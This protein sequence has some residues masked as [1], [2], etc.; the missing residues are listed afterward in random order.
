MEGGNGRSFG[1]DQHL[2]LAGM[3]ASPDLTRVSLIFGTR[4]EAIKLAPLVRAMRRRPG[5]EPHVCVTGQHREMLD[6]VLSAL[7]V[8]PDCDL[9][10]MRPRQGLAELTARTLTACDGYLA[11][12]C[13]SLVV[14]QG[15]TTTALAAAMAA[16]YRRI[17]VAHLEAGLRT[18]RKDS[19]F[20]EEINRQ[21]V[22]R[23]ADYHFAP[24]EGARQNLLAE[25]VPAERIH[26][27]GNTG[28]DALRLAL[29]RVRN[30]GSHLPPELAA[31]PD[32]RWVLVTAHRR[33]NWGRPV[34]AICR[35]VATLAEW[36]PEV[37]FVWPVHLNPSVR[38]PVRRLLGEAANVLL[39]DPLGYLAFVATMDRAWLILTDSGGIQEEA[40][41]LG[42]PVLVLRDTTERGEVG[43]CGTARLVGTEEAAIVAEVARLLTDPEAYAAMARVARP[44]G[45]G[46]ASNR[47]LDLLVPDFAGRAPRAARSHAA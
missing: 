19:P 46:R 44:Y 43:A 5:L 27:T 24:T 1:R 16:F 38:E 20:P 4:P 34:E 21:L 10:L 42:K 15:D 3:K 28:I 14:V 30:G 11:D 18:G 17:P 8:Q 45:D 29:G 7:G 22:A 47:I 25:G 37:G 31:H 2:F 13:P 23:L 36:F 35:A 39:L 40:P 26:V 12:A 9:A 6:Q 33:E 41:A 32:R